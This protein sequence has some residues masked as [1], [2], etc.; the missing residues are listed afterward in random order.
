MDERSGHFARTENQVLPLRAFSVGMVSVPKFSPIPRLSIVIPIGHNLAAFE[1]TLVS[2]LENRPVGCEVLVAHDGSY[3]DPFDLCDEVEFVTASSN[4]QVHLVATGVDQARGRFVHILGDGI[5]ATPGWTEEALECFAE[6]GVGSVTPLVR[7]SESK[8]IVAAGWRDTSWRLC[9]PV[10]QGSTKIDTS[11]AE[12]CQGAYLPVSFWRRDLIGSLCDAFDAGG[13]SVAA[14]YA[15]GK[16]L[17][18][19]GWR[20]V[21]AA[22]SETICDDQHDWCQRLSL[23]QGRRLRAI[24]G[25]CDGS[26]GFVWSLAAGAR[27]LLAAALQPSRYPGSIGQAL[28]PLSL[29]KIAAQMKTDRVVPYEPR[30]GEAE[31]V[32]LPNRQPPARRAA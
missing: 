11:C 7:D 10:G 16:L 15:Y 26:G 14:G 27:S 1:S 2:V 13:C 8:L 5:R 24:Q 12:S 25:V 32:K 18:R 9:E 29:R 17:S 21:V 19:S 6:Q 4:R 22:E 3:D 20:N 28:A 31:I 23:G 30:E